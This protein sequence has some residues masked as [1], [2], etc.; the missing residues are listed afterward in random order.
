MKLKH[1]IIGFSFFI[2]LFLIA[3]CASAGKEAMGGYESV[4]SEESQNNVIEI[5]EDVLN[6]NTEVLESTEPWDSDLTIDEEELLTDNGIVLIEEPTVIDVIEEDVQVLDPA[7]DKQKSLYIEPNY[8]NS[9]KN[10]NSYNVEVSVSWDSIDELRDHGKN[11]IYEAVTIGI[12]NGPSGYFG[13]QLFGNGGKDTKDMILFSFWD[14]DTMAVPIN[15][16]IDGSCKR[17]CQDGFCGGE[18]N[19][20]KCTLLYPMEAGTEYT[21]NMQRVEEFVTIESQSGSVWE[22]SVKNQKTQVRKVVGR[23]LFVNVDKGINRM[24]YFHEHLGL[25]PCQ[26]FHIKTTITPKILDAANVIT[27]AYA[28]VIGGAEYTCQSYD[29]SG[30]KDSQSFIF[31]T[32][33]SIEPGF[34]RGD[35]HPVF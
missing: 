35:K 18:D 6:T 24:K 31:E 30:D 27:S 1:L 21:M 33:G 7:F 22:L 34:E 25:T 14:N 15:D 26:S 13:A 4:D 28:T 17:N 23:M 8:T 12:A 16:G 20:T 2:G 3:S 19:G 5:Q 11:G 10:Q 29:V 9:L 32:G